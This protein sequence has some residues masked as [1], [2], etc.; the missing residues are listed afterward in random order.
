[1]QP[2]F[3]AAL[4]GAFVGGTI[5]FFVQL[6]KYRVD[7]VTAR[8]D[9]LC[10]DLAALADIASEFWLTERKSDSVEL[11]LKQARIIGRIES[12]TGLIEPFAIWCPKNEREVIRY[13]VANLLD[14]TTG[15]PFTDK[16]RDSDSQRAIA[17]QSTTAEV[18]LALD[19]GLRI[20]AK[21]W[22]SCLRLLSC[23]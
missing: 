18:I 15:G 12:L 4:L 19:G 13:R 14:V 11:A 21:V 9:A 3:V 20:G 5:S 17:I 22:P 6:W 16:S 23:Q 7:R 2:A 1:V 8:C 10:A